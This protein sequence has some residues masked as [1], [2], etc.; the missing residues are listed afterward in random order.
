MYLLVPSLL[1]RP[2]AQ[3]QPDDAARLIEAGARML[4][5]SAAWQLFD[6]TVNTVA[7]ALRAAGDTAFTLKARLV[8]AWG[9]FFPGS[10]VGVRLLGGSDVQAMLWVV[11]YLGL[12]AAVLWLRFR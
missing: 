6:A 4:M 5:L 8:L 2:F 1:M 10:Y 3:G 7:E 12:L 11:L 9:I